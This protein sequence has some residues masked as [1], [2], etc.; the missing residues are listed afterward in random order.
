MSDRGDRGAVERR[1]AGASQDTEVPRPHDE[2]PSADP[3]PGPQAPAAP[4]T[5]TSD[6]TRRRGLRALA[7]AVAVLVVL[8]GAY[9]GALWLLADRVPSGT[10][11]AGVDIGGMSADAA[12]RVLQD[13]LAG[14][15]THPVPVSAGDKRTSLDPG[16]AGLSLDARATVDQVTG[17]G[18]D[19]ARLWRQVFGGGVVTPVTVVDDNALDQVLG[20]VAAALET[21]PVDGTVVFVGTQIRTTA[22]S[23]GTRVDV[24]AARSL[25]VDGW[26]T[27]PRPVELPTI[28][29]TPTIDQ[30]EVDRAV[31]ELATPVESAPVT[32]DVA[33][34]SAELPVSVLTDAASFEP[35]DGTLTLTMDGALLAD[36][37][38]ARTTDLLTP[39]ADATF[40]FKDDRPVV[41][42]G[43]PGTTLDPDTLGA[44]VA[45]AATSTGRTASVTLVPTEPQESTAALDALGITEIVS[46]FVTPLTSNHIRTIN[47]A[48]GATKINGVLVRP[49][50][51]FSLGD[52]ISPIDAAH[53]YV[54][55]GAIVNGEHT[56][57]WG[58]G[59]SQLSTTTYNAAYFAGMDLVEHTPHSEYF[60]RYPEGR[61]A[62]IFIPTLDMKWRNN[63]PYGA[64]IQAWV[65]PAA[66]NVHVRIWGTKYW[67]VQSSTS[68][69]WN[70][71]RPTTVYSQSP[72]CT[73]QRAGNPGF[74]VKVTR[75]VLLD[76]EETSHRSWT[77]TYRP[78]NEVVCGAP[79][80]SA[81]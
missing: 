71:H 58:G 6:R 68:G 69:R 41:V 37:V 30:A 39:A 65:D 42:P 11:V 1:D 81:G 31:R 45:K 80:T 2:A 26:L 27:A 4:A 28:V 9:V 61:E 34:Q 77:V 32:V 53:G 36:A 52:T 49:G 50:E 55:A 74:T 46:E 51:T 19:P 21:A 64:L 66:N 43:T 33:G 13:G 73:P 7:T 23:D 56:E 59:L 15:T 47:I 35:R 17:F 70:V 38:R 67:T 48:N 29:E 20:T 24:P 5:P 44:A 63:T 72:T 8:A 25:L 40:V 62:T 75:T 22:P 16:Q 76:G 18:L 3:E 14:A 10:V 54:Q 79:P 60:Q 78:Q 12:V 57:A